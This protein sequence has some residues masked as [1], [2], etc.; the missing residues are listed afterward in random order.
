MLAGQGEM[1]KPVV[2][3]LI[4]LVWGWNPSLGTTVISPA[5]ELGKRSTWL[6]LLQ[7]AELALEPL[8][9]ARAFVSWGAVI[10]AVD[11]EGDGALIT[12]PL[13]PCSLPRLFWLEAL[14][15]RC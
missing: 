10:A 3:V 1:K 7:G 9:R 14:L 2:F 15:P 6:S 8:A 12:Q 11:V 13:P 4:C 5:A